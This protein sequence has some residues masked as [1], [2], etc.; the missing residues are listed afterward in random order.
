MKK[1]GLILVALLVIII[2]F[3]VYNAING[4]V[5]EVNEVVQDYELLFKQ[6]E[7]GEKYDNVCNKFDCEGY[8]A[9]DIEF[10]GVNIKNVVFA[11]SEHTISLEFKANKLFKAELSDKNGIIQKKN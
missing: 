1:T 9:M 8:V 4:F 2:F 7:I 11:N 10:N 5:K 6:I 3:F